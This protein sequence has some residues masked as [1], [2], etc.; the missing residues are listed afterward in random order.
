MPGVVGINSPATQETWSKRWI[1]TRLREGPGAGRCLAL[2]IQGPRGCRLT[3]RNYK[4]KPC[5][6]LRVIGHVRLI[7]VECTFD[8]DDDNPLSLKR[9]NGDDHRDSSRG[10]AW[11]QTVGSSN[12]R[13]RT[14]VEIHS[15]E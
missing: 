11:L 3:Y 2:L 13:R 4:D 8:N 1:C 12:D 14:R 6:K 7:W 10:K 5:V 9:A 15:A